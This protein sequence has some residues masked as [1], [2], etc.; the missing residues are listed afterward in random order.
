MSSPLPLSAINQAFDISQLHGCKRHFIWLLSFRLA[1]LR[2]LLYVHASVIRPFIVII[3]MTCW[4]FV[5][6]THL[7]KVGTDTYTRPKP[8]SLPFSYEKINL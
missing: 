2:P 1:P 5:Y 7:G 4:Y 6:S 8:V 3:T